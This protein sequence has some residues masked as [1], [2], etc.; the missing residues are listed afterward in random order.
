LFGDPHKT[1]LD[2]SHNNFSPYY[3]AASSFFFSSPLPTTNEKNNNTTNNDNNS[4]LLSLSVLFLVTVQS[5]TNKFNNT[6][7][8]L[9]YFD[10]Q[11]VDRQQQQCRRRH[12]S[13]LVTVEKSLVLKLLVRQLQDDG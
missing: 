1:F 11:V 3:Y 13:F 7:C 2:F 5:K 6:V 8:R 9:L 4:H 12:P 10:W